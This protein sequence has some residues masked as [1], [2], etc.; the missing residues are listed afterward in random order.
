MTQQ[1]LLQNQTRQ[2]E[3][4]D[5]AGRTRSFEE[6]D[7]LLLLLPT[8]ENKLLAKWQSPSWVQQKVSPVTYTVHIPSRSKPVQT[9]HVILLK[10]WHA[11][12]VSSVS[13]TATGQSSPE[14]VLLI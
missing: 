7:E 10:K 5:R 4:Y 3:W 12:P 8:S 11:Q 13:P 6:G 1:N 9:F 2:K 14:Q